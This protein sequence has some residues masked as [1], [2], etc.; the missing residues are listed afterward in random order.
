MVWSRFHRGRRAWCAIALLLFGTIGCVQRRMTIRSNPPGALV[1]VDDYEIGTTPASTSFTYYG[2]RK[3]R[4]VKDGYETLTVMQRFDPP[5]YEFFPIDFVS[6]N[7]VPW[8]LRDTRTI[9]FQLVPQRVVPT[10][11]LLQR[12]EN[13]R[14]RRRLLPTETISAPGQ[15]PT[16]VAPPQAV[17]ATPSSRLPSP[18]RGG[19]VTPPR[20]LQ[21][22]PSP[23][24]FAPPGAVPVGGR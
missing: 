7:V 5:W 18:N 16:I 8:E 4:I 6:E 12:G 11:Q 9:D 2:T 3:I 15:V 13:L 21:S 22:P 20:N 14:Q 1:Y 10:E 19:L 17:P 24:G 23:Q